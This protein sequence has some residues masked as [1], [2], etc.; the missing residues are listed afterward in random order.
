MIVIGIL[1]FVPLSCHTL[2]PVCRKEEKMTASFVRQ[3]TVVGL[4]LES[5]K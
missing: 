5:I 2:D 1:Y 4:S 3:S